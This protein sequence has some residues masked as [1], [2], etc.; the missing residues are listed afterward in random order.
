[1]D[2][3][4]VENV[5][6]V[7]RCRQQRGDD[8]PQCVPADSEIPSQG[9]NG[10]A[11]LPASVVLCHNPVQG[12]RTD[13]DGELIDAGDHPACGEPGLVTR[14]G[15]I[16]YHSVNVWPTPDRNGPWGFGP[17]WADP[18]TGEV[19]QGSVNVYG[20]VTD[21]TARTMLDRALWYAGELGSRE[22]TTGDYV[23][24][25][26]A[27]G[28]GAQ[29]SRRFLLSKQEIDRRL[30]GLQHATA[31]ALSRTAELRSSVANSGSNLAT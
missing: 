21:R 13:G 1:M 17:S 29:D 10:I 2:G 12:P 7:L 23:R 24:N 3:V 31:E 25:W 6:R 22:I 19:I 16:R 27:A 15:D 9:P 8:D 28:N 30:L 5:R 4:E 26:A 11:A 14:V 20:A 18:L